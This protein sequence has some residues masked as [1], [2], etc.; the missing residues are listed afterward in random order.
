MLFSIFGKNKTK[1]TIQQTLIIK[2]RNFNINKNAS[3]HTHVLF[4]GLYNSYTA[5]MA[6]SCDIY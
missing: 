4:I 6:Q 5:G 2:K 1:Y 3:D